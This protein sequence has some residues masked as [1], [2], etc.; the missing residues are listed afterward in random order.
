MV[1]YKAMAEE[2]E[3]EYS[4]KPLYDLRVSLLWLIP[5]EY[6]PTLMLFLGV[7]LSLSLP[8]PFAAAS[9]QPTH[10]S[11]SADDN[12]GGGSVNAM[13]KAAVRGA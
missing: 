4:R 1:S 5:P 11:A 8:A 7:L 13:L 3:P 12:F 9:T 10:L 2:S 6:L